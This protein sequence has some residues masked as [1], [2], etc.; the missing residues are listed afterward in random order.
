[1][2]RKSKL[3]IVEIIEKGRGRPKI[4]LVEVIKNNLSIKGIIE[5]VTTIVLRTPPWILYYLVIATTRKPS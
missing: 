5:N 3:I 4:A 2:V 1:M